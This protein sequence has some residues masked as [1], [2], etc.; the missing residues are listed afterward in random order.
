MSV[1]TDSN[2]TTLEIEEVDERLDPYLAQSTSTKAGGGLASQ[3]SG[4]RIILA[5]KAR[6]TVAQYLALLNLLTNGSR[7]YYYTPE[8]TYTLFASVTVPW[9]C[10]VTDL[11]SSWDNRDV[12]Y[13]TFKVTSS[14]FV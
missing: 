13:I 8:E 6:A 9:P 5:C 10:V 12:H 4:K 2:G 3:A 14:E 1:F 7:R 11:Q